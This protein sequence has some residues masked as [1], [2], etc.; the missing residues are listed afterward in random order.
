[1][2]LTLPDKNLLSDTRFAGYYYWNYKF[3]IKYIQLYKFEKILELFG[4]TS[5]S[6]LL[7]NDTGSGIF[8]PEL[9]KH[10]NRIYN[11]FDRQISPGYTHFKLIKT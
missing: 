5:Y 4:Q 6:V 8:L 1:M 9:S 2:S 10:Y 7:E 3:P 11:P